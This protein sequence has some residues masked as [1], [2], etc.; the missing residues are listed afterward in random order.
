MT[1]VLFLNEFKNKSRKSVGCRFSN[2]IKEFALT[3][4][5]L[6]IIRLKH[7]SI[8]GNSFNSFIVFYFYG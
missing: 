2:E 5:G 3:L 6:T 4:N 7:L 1:K 8:A